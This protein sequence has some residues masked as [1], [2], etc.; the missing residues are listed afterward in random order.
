M[1]LHSYPQAGDVVRLDGYYCG[2]KTGDYAVIQGVVGELRDRF[3]ACF[4]ASAYR[5]TSRT[6]GHTIV[7]CSGGPVPEIGIEDLVPTGETALRSFWRFKDGIV[8]AGRAEYYE[9]EVAV[10]SW[11]P[12]RMRPRIEAALRCYRFWEECDGLHVIDAKRA[13]KVLCLSVPDRPLPDI[14]SL[15][16]PQVPRSIAS[17]VKWLCVKAHIGGLS[18]PMYLCNVLAMETGQGDGRGEFWSPRTKLTE[19]SADQV[20]KRIFGSYA[21]CL[22]ERNVAYQTVRNKLV[23]CLLA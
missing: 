13:A 11:T 8:G 18:D 3:Y 16:E 20:A 22:Y 17:F 12:D 1:L 21:T 10:W 2:A 5:D 9:E 19:E 7:S 6:S 14:D 15:I 4:T 23:P